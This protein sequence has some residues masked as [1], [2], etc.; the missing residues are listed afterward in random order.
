MILSAWGPVLAISGD[1]SV[2][3]FVNGYR[4]NNCTDV[5]NAKKFIDPAHPKAGPFGVDAK[6]DPSLQLQSAVKFD[7]ALSSLNETK[8]STTSAAGG[9]ATQRWQGSQL[10]VSV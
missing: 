4:C 1:Y 10:D 7:G 6:N 9:V 3:V 2:P 5:A 8:D